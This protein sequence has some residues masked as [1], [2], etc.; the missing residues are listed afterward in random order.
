VSVALVVQLH[1]SVWWGEGE[2]KGES[3][4]ERWHGVWAREHD[5]R[6]MEAVAAV[7]QGSE[8][9]HGQGCGGGMRGKVSDI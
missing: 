5:V 6:R 1:G 4:S 7:L 9:G 2:G 8:G 3:E